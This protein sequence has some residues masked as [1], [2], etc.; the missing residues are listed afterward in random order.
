MIS[1]DAF[2]AFRI[3]LLNSHTSA[4]LLIVCVHPAIFYAKIFVENTTCPDFGSATQQKYI[5]EFF[6]FVEKRFRKSRDFAGLPYLETLYLFTISTLN[7]I[8]HSHSNT[9]DFWHRELFKIIYIFHLWHLVL[10]ISLYTFDGR[11]IRYI[12][13]HR[14]TWWGYPTDMT[15]LHSKRTLN[16][17]KH[18]SRGNTM[19]LVTTFS[20]FT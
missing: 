16:E 6:F 20:I 13:D 19:S 15:A 17:N 11:F 2:C 9:T 10:L 4:V 8:E 14:R 5:L 7:A 12:F 18:G 1:S 3:C